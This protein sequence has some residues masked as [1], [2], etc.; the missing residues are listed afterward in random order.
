[1]TQG[2]RKIEDYGNEMKKV[3]DALHDVGQAVSPSTLLL[4]LLRGLNFCYNTTADIIAGTAGMTF[5]TAVDQ[6]KLKELRLENEAKVEATNA[7]VASS[8]LAAAAQ[9]AVH[10]PVPSSR[11]LHSSSRSRVLAA[12]LVV[13]SNSD[14]AMVASGANATTADDP[15]AAVVDSNSSL[16]PLPCWSVDLH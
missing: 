2:D 6:L 1:M 7:L 14:R 4:S 8:S 5:A 11:C 15:T 9:T 13:S 16:V 10:R 12:P 3:A